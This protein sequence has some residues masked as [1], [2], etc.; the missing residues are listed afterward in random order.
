MCTFDLIILKVCGCQSFDLQEFHVLSGGV[1]FWKIKRR[2]MPTSGAVATI[3][4]ATV[5]V[6]LIASLPWQVGGPVGSFNY[7][8][9]FWREI[10]F[11]CPKFGGTNIEL[12]PNI[13][14]AQPPFPTLSHFTPPPL[15]LPSFLRRGCP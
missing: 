11:Q 5:I 4:I 1:R 12:S 7:H 15:A 14:S 9:F 2:T 6:V 3:I 8:K 13:I 10:F